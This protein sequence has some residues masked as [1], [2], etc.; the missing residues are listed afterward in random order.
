MSGRQPCRRGRNSIGD[1]AA[2]IVTV[3]GWL[4]SKTEKYGVVAIGRNEGDRL[5]CCL[6]SVL[7]PTPAPIV[8]YVDSGSTDG[9]A[10]FAVSM[11]V[12]VVHLDTSIPFTA[13]RARNAGFAKLLEVCPLVEFVLLVDGDCEVAA[14]WVPTGKAFLE[15]HPDVVAV[16]GT[17]RERYPE[18]SIYNALCDLSWQSEVGETRSFGGDVLL[19]ARALQD[20][21]G[22]DAALIAG[23]ESELCIR[24]RRAG[25]KVWHLDAPMTIHDANILHFGQWWRRSTRTGWAYAEGAAMNGAPPERH[26]VNETRR[27]CLWGILL[28]LLA[29]VLA[30]I[31]PWAGLSVLALYPIQLARL[32]YRSTL[33]PRLARIQ[34]AFLMIEKFAEAAGVV[35]YHVARLGGASKGII[36][37]K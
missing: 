31:Q 6:R 7:A 22:Y 34:S 27:A 1:T 32:V 30:L 3:P 10:E 33:E 37:Y 2:Q 25:W 17:R 8:V 16:S 26:W 15:A 18:R 12:H 4:M 36:E 19:R 35:K 13:A 5:R 23:E 11:G 14:T 20:V 9:S 28:P 29:L 21:G 24:L